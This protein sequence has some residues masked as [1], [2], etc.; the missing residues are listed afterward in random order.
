KPLADMDLAALP[1]RAADRIQA[2]AEAA[3]AKRP[4]LAPQ[5]LKLPRFD[6]NVAFDPDSSVIRPQ[7]YQAIGR[8][9]DA[10]SDPKLQ[11]YTFLV[12]NH[13]AATGARAANVTLS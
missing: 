5:L 1:R 11:P 7:S 10:L 4:P 3:A 8:I 12:I 13:T 6:V 2:R 9:A